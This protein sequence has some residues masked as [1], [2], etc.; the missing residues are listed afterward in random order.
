MVDANDNEAQQKI[1][2]DVIR[3][4]EVFWMSDDEDA[5]EAIFNKF[6]EKYCDKFDGDYDQPDQN[7]NKLE[8]TT[9]HKEY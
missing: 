6:A 2:D 8:Y 5:G 3:E 1:I 4:L 7:D 9:I